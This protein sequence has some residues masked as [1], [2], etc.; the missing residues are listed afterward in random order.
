MYQRAGN[1]KRFCLYCI[2]WI[3]IFVLLCGGAQSATLYE[4]SW[5][6][7]KSRLAGIQKEPYTF[8]VMGDS[9]DNDEVFVKCLLTAASYHPLFILHT[10]DA[11]STGSE[12]RFLNF[13]ALLQKTIPD[14][15]VFVAA[16]NHE[17]THKDKSEYSRNQFHV[18]C[19]GQFRIFSGIKPD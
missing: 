13:L 15:P 19:S 10:G 8:V 17:L 6:K 4:Q 5:Q 3:L 11:V 18:Y 14:I 1:G 12:E 9:R 2:G 7:L 16:G